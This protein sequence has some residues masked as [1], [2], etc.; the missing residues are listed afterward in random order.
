VHIRAFGIHVEDTVVGA[1]ID[2]TGARPPVAAPHAAVGR[3]GTRL[4]L[5]QGA[6]VGLAGKAVGVPDA[7]V[8]AAR[9]DRATIGCQR[10]EPRTEA[11]I[12]VFLQHIGAWVDMR[13]G[14]VDTEAFLHASPP[15]PLLS[16][17]QDR[18]I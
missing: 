3:S 10:V 13:V 17:T 4:G 2:H 15:L 8:D 11:R 9:F 6:L 12:D 18:L 5:A 7:A 14:V 16:L 1:V